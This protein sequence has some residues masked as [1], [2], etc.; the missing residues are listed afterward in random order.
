MPV[1]KERFGIQKI[2]EFYG[3]TEGNAGLINFDNHPGAVGFMFRLFPFFN[4]GY[5]VKVDVE[6]GKLIRDKKGLAIRCKSK[7]VGTFA[8]SINNMTKFHGYENN[9]QE[10]ER[11]I[12]RNVFKEGDTAFLSG[13][14][15]VMDEYYYPYFVDRVGDTF[16]WKS[17]NVSPTEVENIMSSN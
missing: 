13:D 3:A 5:L 6:T 12:A 10:T 16:R 8:I 14:L 7:E 1:V 9:K 11:K 4:P 17:E 2:Y 15:L